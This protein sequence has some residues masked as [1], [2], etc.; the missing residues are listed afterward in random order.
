MLIK[1]VGTPASTSSFLDSDF[2]GTKCHSNV[3]SICPV[4]CL[5]N[6]GLVFSL[7]AATGR[8]FGDKDF[9]GALE[10]GILLCE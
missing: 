9:R 1:V 7:Q 6:S 5:A 2:A 10:N 3:V 4:H 8:C